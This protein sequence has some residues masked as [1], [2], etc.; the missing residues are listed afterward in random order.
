MKPEVSILTLTY[1]HER[2]ISQCLDS[3]I[4]Q[5]FL[6][7]EQIIIDDGS[8]DGTWDIIQQYAKSD[9]RIQAFRQT[10]IGPFRMVQ[11]YNRALFL[12][13]GR[14]IAILEGD[15]RWP[16]NKLEIQSSFHTPE[17]I[18]SYGRTVIIDEHDSDIGV[19]A[20]HWM[21]DELLESWYVRNS[22]LLRRAGIMPVSVMLNRD[23]LLS[24]GGF[25]TDIVV[26]PDGS[27]ISFPAIDYPTFLRYL[28]IKGK[29]QRINSALGSWRQHPQQTTQ[30]YESVFHEGAYQLALVGITASRQLGMFKKLYKAHRKFASDFYLLELRNALDNNDRPKAINAIKRLLWWGG[31][32]RRL[33][34]L[35]GM[36]ALSQGKNMEVPFK[37]YDRFLTFTRKGTKDVKF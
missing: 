14:H 24:M 9:S 4:H 27:R 23:K 34:A 29:V 32:K 2:Y 16:L 1:N 33:E 19:Y 17:V 12:S 10:N 28:L 15:D 37:L 13:Q 31:Q 20:D 5:T 7:W 11:T 21:S 26:M 35:Y 36:L 3:V 8:T 18:F 30:K 25:R 6:P 22:L